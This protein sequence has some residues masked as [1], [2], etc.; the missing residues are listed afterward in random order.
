M[1]SPHSI[2][3]FVGLDPRAFFAP[4]PAPPDAADATVAL[5]AG[6]GPA[7]LDEQREAV[8]AEIGDTVDEV[9]SDPRLAAAAHSLPIRTGQRVVVLGDSISAEAGSW[10]DLLAEV[11][12]RLRP[13]ATLL[14]WSLA[15]RTTAETVAALAPVVA[16]RP[17]WV[18]TMIGTNDVRRHGVGSGVRMAS[19]SAIAHARDALRERLHTETAAQLITLTPPPI[20]PATV[21]ANRSTGVWWELAD[22]AEAVEAALVDDPTAIDVHA[23][24]STGPDFWG[25]DGIHPTRTGQRAIL[26]AVLDGFR[27]PRW[28]GP[29]VS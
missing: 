14:N 2:V 9:L 11:L 16:H 7:D 17:D 10:A 21:A 6:I 27:R 3:R 13:G 22:I 23:T 26:T 20:N 8:R 4:L 29:P 28:P 1:T 12:H 24:V 5:W 15:G 19:S 25:A 18:I